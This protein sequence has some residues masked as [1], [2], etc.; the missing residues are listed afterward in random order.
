MS[1][2]DRTMFDITYIYVEE[3]QQMIIDPFVREHPE[4]ELLVLRKGASDFGDGAWVRR[5]HPTIEALDLDILFYLDLTMGPVTTRLAMAKVRA[6]LNCTHHENKR[7]STL[8]L[9]GT[10]IFSYYCTTIQ[11]SQK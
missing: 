6:T 8:R 7:V 1:R 5:W 3:N 2:L 4:D 11:S 9:C 10:I